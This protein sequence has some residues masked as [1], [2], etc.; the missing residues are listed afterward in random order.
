MEYYDNRFHPT[1]TN[2]F[3]SANGSAIEKL[4]SVDRGYTFVYRM[5][6]R[7][8]G[9]I[10]NT[11]IDIYASGDFGCNIRDAVTGSYHS[12]KVG[13]YAEQLFFKVG[14]STGESRSKNGSSTLFFLSPE[15]YEKHLLTTVSQ[16]IKNEWSERRASYLASCKKSKA[17]I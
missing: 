5:V 1:E 16:T 6:E 2:D 4:K 7:K 12:E 11:K 14:L 10:K 13:S 3:D 17:S 8:N 9:K 15:Q